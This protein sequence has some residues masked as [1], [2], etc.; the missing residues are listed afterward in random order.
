MP[1]WQ[2]L[3]MGALGLVFQVWAGLSFSTPERRD[4]MDGWSHL[5]EC[6]NQ[7]T[8]M[9]SLFLWVQGL[10]PR[11]S[12]CNKR[13]Q[14]F[15][16]IRHGL[17]YACTRWLH[18]TE[19][20]TVVGVVWLGRKPSWCVPGIG[21]GFSER[22]GAKQMIL[23]VSPGPASSCSLDSL[24]PHFCPLDVL[25]QLWTSVSSSLK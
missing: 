4:Y 3:F 1:C 25:A 12:E 22:H 17:C 13:N 8:Y 23:V 21:V 16:S 24:D 15:C 19:G 6:K 2:D 11:V 5:S 20:P 10:N 9:S 7:R 14:A 18:L